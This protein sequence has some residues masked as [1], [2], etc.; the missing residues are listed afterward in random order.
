VSAFMVVLPLPA[1]GRRLL[2]LAAA[3][4]S[5]CGPAQ[6]TLVATLGLATMS[7]NLGPDG[8]VLAMFRGFVTD[9]GHVY[10][11]VGVAQ[12]DGESLEPASTY[13][14]ALIE[15]SPPF[16]EEGHLGVV[17]GG[18]LDVRDPR[19][20]PWATWLVGGS[21][22]AGVAVDVD[23]TWV[24][25][26]G[27]WLRAVGPEGTL[28]WEVDLGAEILAQPAIGTEGD[29][30]AVVR[31]S[32][33]VIAAARVDALEGLRWT[34]PVGVT[35]EPLLARADG[36][37]VT[38]GI[39]DEA[40]VISTIVTAIE[41]ADGAVRWTVVLPG[42]VNGL[43]LHGN[44]DAVVG[45]DEGPMVRLSSDDGATVAEAL[46]S[47]RPGPVSLDDR[48][49]AW[50]SCFAGLCVLDAGLVEVA[51]V[52][53][54]AAEGANRPVAIEA[55][56]MAVVIDQTLTTWRVPGVDAPRDGWCRAGGGPRGAGREVGR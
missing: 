49:R 39:G 30:V 7:P 24:V 53:T 3:L 47:P 2:A 6:P 45:F 28:A 17:A 50:V 27:T 29:V 52:E 56:W 32:E 21:E 38:A 11:T 9:S 4:A 41:A 13:T 48:G 40:G 1:T 51:Q 15:D 19:G 55:G 14:G 18:G 36:L 42:Y 33:G 5:G 10:N 37:V 12:L 25:P 16:D 46:I 23:G 35:S 20:G 34:T 44:G 31:D 26:A 43:A 22:T 8:Q 54:T